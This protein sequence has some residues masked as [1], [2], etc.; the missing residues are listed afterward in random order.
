MTLGTI[1]LEAPAPSHTKAGDNATHLFLE[2]RLT[3]SNK[4][5]PFSSRYGDLRHSFPGNSREDIHWTAGAV[6]TDSVG[7][8]FLRVCVK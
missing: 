5:L 7:Y 2:A 1:E 8:D 6:V 4:I 3:M